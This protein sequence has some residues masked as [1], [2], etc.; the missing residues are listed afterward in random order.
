MTTSETSICNAALRLIKGGRIDSLDEQSTIAS[1]CKE[2]YPVARDAVLCAHP[3]NFATKRATLTLTNETPLGSEYSY[4]YTL[5][6][7]PYC[8]R[9]IRIPEQVYNMTDPYTTTTYKNIGYAYNGLVDNTYRIEGRSLVT[10]L[11][12]VVIEYIARETN[13]GLFPPYFSELLA[14]RI[15]LDLP[16]SV[17]GSV[18]LAD[19][20][21]NLYQKR[22]RDAKSIDGQEGT[23]RKKPTRSSYI[24]ARLMGS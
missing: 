21:D 5:P 15:A 6:T 13:A 1:D 18:S 23:Y 24:T 17:S 19:R 7:N 10:N 12:G 4:K 11:T 20:I 3:W 9:V 16:Y 2:I 14:A 22:L 8:L